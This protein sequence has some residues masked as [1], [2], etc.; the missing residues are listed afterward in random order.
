[1][2]LS[3]IQPIN[4]TKYSIIHS[5]PMRQQPSKYL[6]LIVVYLRYG[7]TFSKAKDFVIVCSDWDDLK[8]KITELA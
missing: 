7:H 8:G 4:V 3:F 1:M 2:T 5:M 6:C